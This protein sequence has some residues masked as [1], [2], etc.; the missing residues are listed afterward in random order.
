MTTEKAARQKGRKETGALEIEENEGLEGAGAGKVQ[1][2][3]APRYPPT[4]EGFRNNHQIIFHSNVYERCD[5]TTLVKLCWLRWDKIAK[6][7][8]SSLPNVADV[9]PI[10]PKSSK[11]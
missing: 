4:Y 11:A 6:R 10:K 9:A 5:R 1:W 8:R 3:L 7:G 2:N